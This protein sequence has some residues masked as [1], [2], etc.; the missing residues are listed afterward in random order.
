MDYDKS[1]LD[2]LKAELKVAVETPKEGPLK[3][4]V[5]QPLAPVDY[6]Q[7]IDML[8]GIIRSHGFA[9]IPQVQNN[10]GRAEFLF[11]DG[12]HAPSFTTNEYRIDLP[13]GMKPEEWDVGL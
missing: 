10:D 3:D 1:K 6:C 12:V 2:A 11:I 4:F 8:I 7:I 13:P 5:G 9:H